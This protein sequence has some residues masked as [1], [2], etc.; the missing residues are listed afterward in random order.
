M[1]SSSDDPQDR[2]EHAQVD[3][4]R[5]LLG[6]QQARALLDGVGQGVDLEVGLDDRLDSGEVLVEQGSGPGL[7]RLPRQG[8]QADDVGADLL[9]SS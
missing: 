8:T 9:I 5:L 3:R 7:D 1:R 2:D 6:R 4:H